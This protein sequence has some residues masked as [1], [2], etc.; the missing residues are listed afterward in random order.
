SDIHL[1]AHNWYE[2]GP[3]VKLRKEMFEVGEGSHATPSELAITWHLYP[4]LAQTQIVEPKVA[5]RGSFR[6]AADFRK[7]FPD[8]R[9][10]SDPSTASVEKG[11]ALFKG[12]VDALAD[13]CLEF[14]KQG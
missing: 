2:P 4:E 14:S 11:A 6:D 10:G 13:L 5:P 1:Q 8:G 3:V 7:N 12:S 9:I